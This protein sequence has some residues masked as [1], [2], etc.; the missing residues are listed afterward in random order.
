MK[1]KLDKSFINIRKCDKNQSSLLNLIQQANGSSLGM[2]N[3]N[4]Q[5]QQLLLQNSALLQQQQQ[6]QLALSKSLLSQGA[7]N[8]NYQLGQNALGLGGLGNAMLD[9]DL[10][11]MQTI[12]ALQ[13]GQMGQVGQVGS[14][15]DMLKALAT[16]RKISKFYQILTTSTE[17]GSQFGSQLGNQLSAAQFGAQGGSGLQSLLN[18]QNLAGMLASPQITQ[19]SQ[20]Q[21]LMDQLLL[22]AQQSKQNAMNLALNKIGLN[23]PLGQTTAPTFTSSVDMKASSSEPKLTQLPEPLKTQKTTSSHPPPLKSKESSTLDKKQ[24]TPESSKSSLTEAKNTQKLIEKSQIEQGKAQ[25]QLRNKSQKVPVQTIQGAEAK[26]PA[27]QTSLAENEK[28]KMETIKEKIHHAVVE[29]TAVNNKVVVPTETNKAVTTEADKAAE[30]TETNKAGST[31]TEKV[32]SAEPEKVPL[33]VTPTFK[34]S[35]SFQLHKDKGNADEL[36]SGPFKKIK[37]ENPPRVVEENQKSPSTISA[38]KKDE[39]QENLKEKLLEE[40]MP[41]VKM[42]STTKVIRPL[43][44]TSPLAETKQ[45]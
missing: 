21:L 33:S 40:S 30:S 43:V 37:V 44:L 12:S 9:R 8:L 27:K 20:S 35:R 14:Q 13:M 25:S 23:N 19:P 41:P 28:E 26:Q 39:N 7:G 22:G 2:G 10:L 38:E 11:Q 1:E 6:Q 5:N 17:L 15:A 3:S 18:Q 42:A 24:L 4:L 16:S 32:V 34:A 29:N 36:R 45:V 31:E